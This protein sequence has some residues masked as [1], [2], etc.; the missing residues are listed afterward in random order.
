MR[1][2]VGCCLLVVLALFVE[3]ST[4][5]EVSGIRA[6]ANL[7]GYCPCSV[8]C[9]KNARF[10]RTSTGRDARARPLGAATDPRV[11]PYGCTILI[12]GVGRRVVDDTGGAMRQDAKRGILHIDVR[13]STHAEA[14]LFGKKWQWVTIWPKARRR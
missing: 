14:R 4:G 13:F 1:K 11:V 7:T 2:S 6:K 9:G 12:P 10:G 3:G 8:C 5:Q